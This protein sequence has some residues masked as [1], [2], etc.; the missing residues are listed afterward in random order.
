MVLSSL[1][2]NVIV[3]KIFQTVYGKM[4]TIHD[5]VISSVQYDSRKVNRGDMFVAISGRAC[6][7]HQFIQDA[8]QNGAKAIVLEN[9]NIL[10]D[11]FFMHAGVTKIVVPNTRKALAEIS[12]NYFNHPSNQLS[13]VGVTG[14]NGKTTTTHIIKAI[15]EEH[16]K[17]SSD[18]K[19]VAL[20][21]T[22]ENKIGNEVL[23]SQLTTPES[24]ELNEILLKVIKKNG[25][26]VVMEVS[27]HA[28]HQYRVYGINFRASVFTNLTQDHLDY[29]GSMEEYFKAKKIL[30]DNL[31][32]SAIAVSNVDDQYGLR[33]LE[34][35][36]AKKITY[37]INS[38]A[39][40]KAENINLGISSTSF[41]ILY[42]SEKFQIVSPL[43]G[44][45][46]VYNIL[47]AAAAAIGLGVDATTIQF[48]LK[49]L[50]PVRGR[51]E[52]IESPEG[53][54]AIVDYAHTPDAL[55]K[56]L[57]AV[58]DILSAD[59]LRRGKIITVFGAGGNRDKSKRPKMGKIAADL[60]DTVIITSDNPRTENPY[61]IMMDIA[62]GI[63]KSRGFLQEI[64][65][66]CAIEK[67]IGMAQ[68]GDVVLIAGKGHE[69]YQI[70]GLEKLHFSDVEFVRQIM[71]K[72]SK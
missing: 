42:G 59:N 23:D 72:K 47:A 54:T 16:E 5:V 3:S 20:I 10:P 13:I 66:R 18:P 65:R 52:R 22:I 68:K 27:S 37:G 45:F 44:K 12:A 14:T 40:V 58:R 26:S 63:D 6:D 39:A 11:S 56:C 57:L 67:A 35:C 32:E 7:G 64:D 28:L 24:L 33:I 70:I 48:A 15:L 55:E 17:K 71:N 25:S 41:S 62:E 9:D 43:I 36:R 51:F 4:V 31:D 1:L 46:N 2:N 29:H 21:G 34:S 60:S 50:L 8:I 19:N 49:S 61:Q 53:W 69:D 30:F 38:N